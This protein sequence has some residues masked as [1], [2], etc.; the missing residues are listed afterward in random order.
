MRP[1]GPPRK[2]GI[3]AEVEHEDD[4]GLFDLARFLRKSE[5]SSGDFE[6]LDLGWFADLRKL[7]ALETEARRRGYRLLAS[8]GFEE[9]NPQWLG[10]DKPTSLRK[11]MHS[12]RTKTLEV[13]GFARI[14]GNITTFWLSHAA[15]E[16]VS[17]PS[18]FA[19]ILLLIR[20]ADERSVKFVIIYERRLMVR[21][22]EKIRSAPA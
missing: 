12:E 9:W 2:N 17:L 6:C 22:L 16:L 18:V 5:T 4:S 1:T 19:H 13:S 15:V 11:T 8:T 10:L 3:L 14:L 20:L 21:M 7:H